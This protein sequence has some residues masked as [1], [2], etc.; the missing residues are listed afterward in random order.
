[1]LWDLSAADISYTLLLALCCSPN[2]VERELGYVGITQNSFIFEYLVGNQRAPRNPEYGELVLNG[3]IALE[4]F[5]LLYQVL[6]RTDGIRAIEIRAS[7]YY[8]MCS[9]RS[10]FD[11]GN[12][13]D[14]KEW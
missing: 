12:K 5:D 7:E 2:T 3:A 6:A 10:I 11:I 13:T 1:M 14:Y 9:K 4:V 8:R